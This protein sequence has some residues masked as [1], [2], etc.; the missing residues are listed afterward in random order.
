MTHQEDP[1]R[2]ARE[3]YGPDEYSQ[4][5]ITEESIKQYFLHIPEYFDMDKVEGM[6]AYITRMLK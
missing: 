1:W 6:R 2:K 3:G 4:V 5:E